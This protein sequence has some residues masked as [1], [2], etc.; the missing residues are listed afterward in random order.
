MFKESLAVTGDKSNAIGYK[1]LNRI[2]RN[3]QEAD[4]R[5]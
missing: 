1:D 3:V 2:L 5:E 4:Y